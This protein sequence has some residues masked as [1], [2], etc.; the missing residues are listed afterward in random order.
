M[1]PEELPRLAIS[2][3]ILL[4]FGYALVVHWTAGVE[5]TITNLVVMAV[6]YWLGSSKGSQDNAARADKALDIAKQVQDDNK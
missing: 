1:K 4:Y 2:A 3:A 5:Q 6:G